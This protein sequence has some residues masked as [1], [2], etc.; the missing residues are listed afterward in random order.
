MNFRKHLLS[1]FMIA[2]AVLS[3]HAVPATP[4]PVAHL[5]PDGTTIMLYLHG[6]EHVHCL[7]DEAGWVVKKD[8][9]GFFKYQTK[10]MLSINRVG[11][12]LPQ[13]AL[14]VKEW[15]MGEVVESAR[16]QATTNPKRFGT[17]PNQGNPVSIV[18]LV[19]FSDC[20]FVTP[21]A[22]EAFKRMLTERGY[23]DNDAT[24]SA[25]DYFTACSQGQFTPQFDVYG[26][27]TLEHPYSYY[28]SNNQWT[29]SDSNP[30]QMIVDA[31]AAADANGV[32]FTLYDTDGDDIID[33]VFVYYAGYNE[34][35]GAEDNTIW[36]HRSVVTEQ[37][38]QGSI[39][40]DGKTVY[41]YACTSELSGNTG[42]KMAAIG[43]FCHEF[44]HVLG[45]PDYYHTENSDTKTLLYWDIMDRGSYLNESRTPPLYSSYDR[46][47]L[48]WI[49]PRELTSPEYLVLEP[50]TQA[51][52]VVDMSNKAF[53]VSETEHNMDGKSPNPKEFFMVE[54]RKKVGW[55][56]YLPSEGILFWHID[57]NQ[58]R[59]TQNTV[60]NYRSTHNG[61]TDHMRVYI[62]PRANT[63][64]YNPTPFTSGDFEPT[65]W[66]GTSLGKPFTDIN[67]TEERAFMTFMGGE[68]LDTVLILDSLTTVYP[69]GISI[70]WTN[71]WEEQTEVNGYYVVVRDAEGTEVMREWTPDTT[72][73]ITG[74]EYDKEYTYTVETAYKNGSYE[75]R[76]P[77]G[78]RTLKTPKEDKN[79]KVSYAPNSFILTVYKDKATD[80]LYIYNMEGRLINIIN[81]DNNLV[82][83]DMSSYL[84]GQIL[85]IKCQ[86]KVAKFVVP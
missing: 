1:L 81:E 2:V 58:R 14:N 70:V 33:N 19:N 5:Q 60:N 84:Q 25:L 41:D 54:Y 20:P 15:Q 11:Q 86:K 44:G 8:V 9:D 55:D 80:Q 56:A 77:S 66:N 47:Y 76:Q 26:P 45:L 7:A 40:F 43:T 51:D 68:P 34:A 18:I 39:V 38:A 12:A 10:D 62:E 22:N 32:D 27:Y 64:N 17:Y 28:G 69:T 67:V 21:N 74:L 46:F 52:T 57:Y 37:N 48:G 63:K 85:M 65:L 4:Y 6:D 50:L 78:F 79:L 16:K 71:V 61:T 23:S 73:T 24:G 3:L 13:A 83:L 35:E 59:W 82:Q 42:E 36:P 49:T 75:V 72:Y 31:C 29:E 53:L 30:R